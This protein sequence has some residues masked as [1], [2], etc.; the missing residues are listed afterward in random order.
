VFQATPGGWLLAGSYADDA[1]GAIP[2]FDSL[3]FDLAALWR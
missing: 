3:A 2:P 1:R